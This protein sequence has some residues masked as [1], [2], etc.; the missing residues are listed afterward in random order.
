MAPPCQFARPPQPCTKKFVHEKGCLLCYF[1][2]LEL[3]SLELTGYCPA[4]PLAFDIKL[5]VYGNYSWFGLFVFHEF[6]YSKSLLLWLHIYINWYSGHRASGRH[7][8]L[9]FHQYKYTQRA[10]SHYHCHPEKT[11]AARLNPHIGERM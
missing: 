4:L 6:M 3:A 10:P 1:Y 7:L 2:F 9:P 8:Q 5:F 11:V